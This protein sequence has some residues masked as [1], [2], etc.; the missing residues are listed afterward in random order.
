M[1]KATGREIP[2]AAREV[3]EFVRRNEGAPPAETSQVTEPAPAPLQGYHMEVEKRDTA[4]RRTAIVGEGE[5]D[6][7]WVSLPVLGFLF[8]WRFRQ[9]RS[10]GALAE[11]T[12]GST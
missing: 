8:F 5:W 12:R 4:T 10:S 11:K 3:E 7:V 2:D 1:Q 6:A 9:R